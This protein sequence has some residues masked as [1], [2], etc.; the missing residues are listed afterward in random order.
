MYF[1]NC[2][3][4]HQRFFDILHLQTVHDWIQH[5]GHQAVRRG[6][7]GAGLVAQL[8]AQR[9]GDVNETPW[10]VINA[11]YNDLRNARGQ[12]FMAPVV[13]SDFQHGH[14]DGGVGKDHEGQRNQEGDHGIPKCHPFN[15]CNVFTACQLRHWNVIAVALRDDVQVTVG[16]GQGVE[17]N[18]HHA[19]EGKNPA[20]VTG[21]INR[22]VGDHSGISEREPYGNEAIQRHHQQYQRMDGPQRVHEIHLSKAGCEGTD[23]GLPPVHSDHLREGHQAKQEVCH[24]QVK[25][26]P[27]LWFPQ[28]VIVHDYSQ[29]YNIAQQNGEQEEEEKSRHEWMMPR[30]QTWKSG[31]DE[32]FHSCDG[33]VYHRRNITE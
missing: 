13:L 5:G 8:K 30:L 28:S 21:N 10:H 18:P 22:S 27:W 6:D 20:Q 7:D 2:E 14:D 24:G 1:P 26:G 3:F 12:D 33:G 29:N 17:H 9:V 25:Q 32:I 4:L 19:Y 11:R 31:D 15:I 16:Q 23:H